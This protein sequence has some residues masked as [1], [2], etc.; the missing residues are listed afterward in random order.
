MIEMARSLLIEKKLPVYFWGEAIRHVIYL[1]N[2]LPTKAVSGT[3]PYEAWSGTQPHVDHIRIFG[4][5]AHMRV[6]NANLKKLDARSKAVIYLGKEPRTKAHRVYDPKTRSIC[7]SRDLVF[8]EDKLLDWSQENVSQTTQ[9]N[10][11]LVVTTIAVSQGEMTEDE[12]AESFQSNTET[13]G[14]SS[15]S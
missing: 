14:A 2:R 8:E 13:A 15:D 1:L 4:F 7:V 11:F 6:P 9:V 10:N 12:N 3:T 5:L